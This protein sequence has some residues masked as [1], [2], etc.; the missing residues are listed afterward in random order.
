MSF[1][2]PEATAGNMATRRPGTAT[3]R[4]M[5]R[6]LRVYPLLFGC[7][8]VFAIATFGIPLL[9]GL[10]T[11]E[12]FDALTEGSLAATHIMTIIG[13]FVAVHVAD[14]VAG[15]G[16]AYF[17][18]TLL[19]KSVALL[20]RNLLRV[21]LGGYGALGVLGST[22]EALNRFQDDAKEVVEFIDR[23]TDLIGRSVFVAAAVLVMASIDARITIVVLVPMAVA[24]TLVNL[25]QNRVVDYRTTSRAAAGSASGF[26]GDLLGAVQVIKVG[27][28]APYAVAHLRT[29]N[30][31]RRTTALRDRVFNELIWAFNFNVANLGTGV[32]LLL[33]AGSMRAGS[34]TVGDFALFATYLGAVIWF[35]IE[36]ADWITGYRQAGV[37]VNRMTTLMQ[38]T[39]RAKVA[40]SELTTAVLPAPTMP[41]SAGASRPALTDAAGATLLEASGLGYRYGG[42][43][44]GIVGVNL[45]LR[46]GSF[47]VITGRVGSGKTTLLEVL[48]G[49]LPHDT[50]QLRWDGEPVVPG[51]FGPPRS[52]YTPQ[53]PRLF[54]ASVRENVLLGWPADQGV[55]QA[56]VHAAVLEDDI[57]TLEHGLDTPI[58]PRGVRLSGGQVQRV[59]AARMFVRA[60]ALLVLDDVSSALDLHTEGVLWER[61]IGSQI[62]LRPQT[63]LAVSHRRAVLRRADHILVM[64]GGKVAAEGT[65]DDLL[66]SSDEFREIWYGE[67]DAEPAGGL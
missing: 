56:A 30:Q 37:S 64:A 3:L 6:L 12:F 66:A 4:F 2:M 11:R 53:T 9:A 60:P 36:V 26:L 46:R 16:L 51:W 5:L 40:E 67:R 65:L 45:S 59:A 1:D 63:I 42:E 57:P 54:S 49:L 33:A 38:A 22:G 55:L 32:I 15:T 8:V 35:P 62:D 20:R 28:A 18:C 50:G 58:G 29:L 34:F 13:L 10:V 7:C 39:T 17:W 47:T 27:G 25:L 21:L 52:A 24:I 43:G 61:L 48:L 14:F 44:K 31:V 23:W 19:F 41:R